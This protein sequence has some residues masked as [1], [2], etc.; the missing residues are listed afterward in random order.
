MILIP[1][2]VPIL[3][4]PA[5]IISKK[6]IESLKRDNYKDLL[7]KEHNINVIRIDATKSDPFVLKK[8]MIDKFH[9]YIHFY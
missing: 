8:N 1:L 5:L 3:F 9:Q 6:D 4:A 7:A 2:E